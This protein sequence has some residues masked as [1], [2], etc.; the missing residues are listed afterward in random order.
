MQAQWCPEGGAKGA[1][2]PPEYPGGQNLAQAA[3]G[4]GSAQAYLTWE[5]QPSKSNG[6]IILKWIFCLL[7]LRELFHLPFFSL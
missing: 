6:L 5:G 7:Y 2:P 1:P 3:A 4:R